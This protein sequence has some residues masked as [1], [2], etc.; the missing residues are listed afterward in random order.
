MQMEKN[1]GGS[2]KKKPALLESFLGRNL[3]N[4][5]HQAAV[6]LFFFFG[7]QPPCPTSSAYRGRQLHTLVQIWLRKAKSAKAGLFM[8]TAGQRLQKRDCPA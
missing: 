2:P 1:K 4:R 5:C 7:D 6:D 3:H 8:V